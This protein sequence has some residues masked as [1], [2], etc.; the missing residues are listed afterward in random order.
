MSGTVKGNGRFCWLNTGS[1]QKSPGTFVVAMKTP[2]IVATG[3]HNDSE[4]ARFTSQ[5]YIILRIRGAWRKTD[6]L[7]MH[8]IAS[9]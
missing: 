7:K 2:K 1:D 4:S 3:L 5:M 9:L 8:T 6:K